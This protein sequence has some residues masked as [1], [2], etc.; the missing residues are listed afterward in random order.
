[1]ASM[2]FDEMSNRIFGL[3]WCLIFGLLSLLPLLRGEAVHVSLA[4]V[5]MIL[6]MVAI[7]APDL[8]GQPNRLWASFSKKVHIIVSNITLFLIYFLL[9]TPGAMLLR[10]CR[11]Q[12][13]KLYFDPAASTYW[14]ERRAGETNFKNPY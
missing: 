12:V 10:L 7:V 8:L 4:A 1:M 3:T 2:E 5:S 9:F 14:V 13:L 6:S 11:R